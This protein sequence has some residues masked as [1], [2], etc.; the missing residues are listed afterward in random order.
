MIEGFF[1]KEISLDLGPLL[2]RVGISLQRVGTASAGL[3]HLSLTSFLAFC[4][5]P[6]SS[7]CLEDSTSL[8][9]LNVI[10]LQ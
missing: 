4:S 3:S 2:Q 5:S 6:L 1:E 9:L 7:L 10:A 8:P